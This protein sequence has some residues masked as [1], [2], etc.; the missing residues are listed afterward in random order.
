MNAP[1]T[2]TG[3]EADTANAPVADAPVTDAPATEAERKRAHTR[4]EQKEQYENNKLFKRLAR[5]VGQ[6]IGDFNMIEEGDKVMVCL[7][8]G[9]LPV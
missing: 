7:S 1:E 5:Q 3:L 6:A 2:L 8:G 9:K 4:R